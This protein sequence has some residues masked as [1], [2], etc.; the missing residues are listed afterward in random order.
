MN[1]NRPY[2]QCVRCVMDT[3]DPDIRFDKDGFCNHCT[4]LLIRK[5]SLPI[6]DADIDKQFLKVVAHVKKKGQGKKYDCVLGISGGLDSCYT[7]V[8]LHKLGLRVLLVHM[9]NGWDTAGSVLNI[10]SLVNRNLFDYESNVLDWEEF[11]DLQV[12]FLR[13]SVV[14]AETPTDVAVIATIYRVAEKY[15]IKYI[16]S[17]SNIAT[18][19]ILP[20]K[21]HYNAIDLRFFKGVHRQFGKIPLKKF[22]IFGF[23][24][25][26]RYKFLKRVK[27]IYPLNAVPYSINAA[28]T[29]VQKELNWKNYGSKH[30]ESKFTAFIHSYFLPLKFN[31][32]Y[33]KA[34]LSSRICIG[35]I[36]REAALLELQKSPYNPDTIQS[37]IDYICKKL[38]LSA[39]EFTRILQAP[40]KTHKDYPNSAKFVE[41]FYKIYYKIFPDSY[42]TPD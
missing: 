21:W 24:H 3:T 15:G 25:L 41:M 42:S 5:Q 8:L 12:A 28:L 37:D 11:R 9:D 31:I 29:T 1:N 16:F 23:W 13:A 32:D 26:V 38:D 10:Q 6:E 36:T 17:G 27:M 14:E 40:P 2:K 18:E 22:P 19:G 39:D 35:E 33:R 4:K 7:A 30:H 20:K 34:T